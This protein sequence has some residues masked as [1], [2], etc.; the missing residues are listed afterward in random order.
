MVSFRPSLLKST[1]LV[2]ISLGLATSAN[3]EVRKWT[4]AKNGKTIEAEYISADVKKKT[5]TIKIKGKKKTVPI[6]AFSKA[7]RKYVVDQ[8]K[9]A[10]KNKEVEL[11]IK[12]NVTKFYSTLAKSEKDGLDAVLSAGAKKTYQSNKTFFDQITTGD[13]GTQ[14]RVKKVE[15]DGKD[16]SA[17]TSLKFRGKYYDLHVGL[18]NEDSNWLVDSLTFEN[19]EGQKQK[20]DFATGQTVDPDAESA[21]GSGGNEFVASRGNDGY[22]RGGQDGYG[23]GPQG[24]GGYAAAGPKGPGPGQGPPP[25]NAGRGPGQGPPNGPPPNGPP[26]PRNGERPQRPPLEDEE[27][28]SNPNDGYGRANDNPPN[29]GYGRAND[30][31]GRANDGYDREDDAYDDEGG[32]GGGYSREDYERR[33]AEARQRA[34]GPPAGYYNNRDGASNDGGQDNAGHGSGNGSVA[35]HDGGHGNTTANATAASPWTGPP[36]FALPPQMAAAAAPEP[37]SKYPPPHTYGDERNNDDDAYDSRPVGHGHGGGSHGHGG[38]HGS[39]RDPNSD[40]DRDASDLKG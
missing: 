26:R 16:A 40:P 13:R 30:G 4:S 3:A 12:R 32:D 27:P 20:M 38:G 1:L 7:D 5:I 15:I 37:V 10:N 24:D 6:G 29:D 19:E 2:L 8:I 9:M 34:G 36:P 21:D 22:G 17:L 33:A 25:P 18:K 28:Q 31:Y 39:G 23:R 14:A 35:G 11:M